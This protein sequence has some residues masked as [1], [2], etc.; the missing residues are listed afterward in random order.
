MVQGTGGA[1]DPAGPGDGQPAGPSLPPLTPAAPGI[2]PSFR[3]PPARPA[4]V[5]P[6]M[7]DTEQFQVAAESDPLAPGPTPSRIEAPADSTGR[8]TVPPAPGIPGD[9]T[10]P[11]GK[12]PEGSAQP[13]TSTSGRPDKP[14]GRTGGVSNLTGWKVA[15]AFLTAI[16]MIAVGWGVYQTTKLARTESAL[17]TTGASA[18]AQLQGLDARV[19]A[20]EAANAQYAADMAAL[21]QQLAT[22]NAAAAAAREE[23]SKVTQVISV[24]P[25]DYQSSLQ[26]APALSTAFST[27]KSAA[28][29]SPTDQEAR[30]RSLEAE[31][32]L[33]GNCAL[34]WAGATQQIY[35]SDQPLET[36][37]KV[38]TDLAGVAPDCKIIT[39]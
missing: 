27:A 20:L 15:T 11:T 26:Q 6:P 34:I 7:G 25:A 13:G 1:P 31:S 30:I 22:A 3:P 24:T 38:A 19:A 8:P 37:S 32:A 17:K 33:L 21:Q 35:Q 39:S 29:S 5:V 10:R 28:D 2:R 16:A 9:P 23:Y 18:L 14:A 36:M 12:R 4:P